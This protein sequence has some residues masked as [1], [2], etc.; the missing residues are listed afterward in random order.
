MKRIIRWILDFWKML[1]IPT[2]NIAS[3]KGHDSELFETFQFETRTANV[4]EHANQGYLSTTLKIAVSP[5]ETS[6]LVYQF[7]RNPTYPTFIFN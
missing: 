3:N 4:S 7:A 2:F 5:Y 1:C 6:L